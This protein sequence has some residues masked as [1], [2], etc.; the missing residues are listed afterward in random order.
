MTSKL[1]GILAAI[2][3]PFTSDFRLDGDALALH[4]ERL[5]TA[6]IGG[7]VTCGSTGE[8]PSLTTF[9]RK[10]VT[11][12]VLEAARGRVPVVVQTGSTRV[13]ETIE[14][15][16][17]AQDLGAEAVMVVA[18]YYE[19]LSWPET[20]SY[21]KLLA[22]S[23]RIPIML[24]HIPGATGRKL[25]A[26][27]VIE[28][29]R[30]DGV[31]SMKDSSNDASL[32]M[33]LIHGLQGQSDFAVFNGW[34]SLNLV[35]LAS[36]A[37]GSVWGMANFIPELCVEFYRSSLDRD[38]ERMQD[39]WNRILPLVT[40]CESHNYVAA[41]KAGCELVGS[42]LGEPRLPILPLTAEE[43]SQ[44]RDL[45]ESAG[46]TTDQQTSHVMHLRIS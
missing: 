27:Q 25:T 3:T 40:F 45:L 33:T 35:A 37:R 18:P 34:D 44:L 28:L 13:D 29:A 14:L 2:A 1:S 7:I 42:R 21:Y 8:F 16:L 38:Q 24:Y 41:V 43:K 26:D 20:L 22:G 30:I 23:L 5:T 4:T 10:V 9:E 46:I 6:E 12:T 31:Q 36:G 19:P 39:L 11:E 17:H 15:S 32:L